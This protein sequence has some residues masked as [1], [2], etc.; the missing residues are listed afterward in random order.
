MQIARLGRA[1]GFEPSTPVA[2]LTFPQ[3]LAI[4]RFYENVCLG[5]DPTLR[6]RRR[7]AVITLRG[8]E[9]PVATTMVQRA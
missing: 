3:W 6:S 1:H 5:R 7:D 4:F 9:A 8:R 2:A